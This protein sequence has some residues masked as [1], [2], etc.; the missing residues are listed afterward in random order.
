MTSH[1]EESAR[2]LTE[3][4]VKVVRMVLGAMISESDEDR[5]RKSG[6]PRATYQQAKKRL[7]SVGLLQDRFVPNPKTL[8]FHVVSIVLLRQFPDRVPSTAAWLGAQPGATNVWS[9]MQS[10][11][12]VCFHDSVSAAQHFREALGGRK[13][14]GEVVAHLLVEPDSKN[15]PVYFDYEGAWNSFAKIPGTIGY[16]HSLPD[17][18]FRRR[19]WARH[20]TGLPDGFVSLVRRPF[21]GNRAAHLVGPATLPRSQRRILEKGALVWRSFLAPMEIPLLDGTRLSEVAFVAGAL[22]KGS[23]SQELLGSLIGRGKV[24]PFLMASDGTQMVLGLLL[25]APPGHPEDPVVDAPSIHG[26]LSAQLVDIVYVKE[27]LANL[28]AYRFHR[29]DLLV[30][31]NHTPDGRG[32]DGN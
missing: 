9:G 5:I 12:G 18:D 13:E 28:N 10:V 11:F 19:F 6:L 29:Y 26:L 3:A 27:P 23:S 7:Y 15:F 20:P 4:E 17:K 25:R 16:P 14:G 2:C 30:E 32:M 1:G 21:E 8:G 22:R 31:N 24:H